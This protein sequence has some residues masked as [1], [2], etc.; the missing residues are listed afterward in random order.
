MK[1]SESWLR[2]WVNPNIAR[3]AL[4]D[5]LTMS[6]FEVEEMSSVAGDF[7]GVTVCEIVEIS[8][9]PNSEQLTVCEVNVG[10]SDRLIVVCGASNVKKGLKTAIAREGSRLPNNVTIKNTTIRDVVSQGMLCSASELGLSDENTGILELPTDA[11]IGKDLR[12]YLA[13]NDYTLTLA[14]MPNRGDCLS[15]KGMSRE[16]AALTDTRWTPLA[17]SET[18]AQAIKSRIDVVVDDKHACPNYVGRIIENIKPNLATPLWLKERLRRANV[19]SISPIVDITNYVMLELGQPMHAFDLSKLGKTIHIRQSKQGEKILLLD[20]S[21]KELNDNSLIIAD[22]NNP[23]A[24]AGVMGGEE[25]GVTEN[26]TAIFLESACFLPHVVAKQRQYYGLNSESAYRFERAVDPT[27]QREALERAT[28]LVLELTGGIPGPVIEANHT[29]NN[30]IAK[31]IILSKDKITNVLGINISSETIC[32]I[33]NRLGLTY[34]QTEQTFSVNIP[35]YRHDLL[36]E[37]DLIEEIAR[38]YGYDKIPMHTLQGDLAVHKQQ[39]ISVN[40]DWMIIR[41]SLCD[42]GYHEIV[43]YSFVDK[44]LQAMLNPSETARELLNPITADMTVMRTNLWP[45]LINTLL[46]NK[47]RQQHRLR[48]F[49][50]GTCFVT[51]DNKL[52]EQSQLGGILMGDDY[53]EQWGITSKKID[54]FDLKGDI[55]NL[56]SY[57]YA[58]NSIEFAQDMHPALHPG[59][60]AAIRIN[61]HH[62]GIMGMLHPMLYQTFDLNEKIALFALDLANLKQPYQGMYREIAKFPE[63]RRDLALLVEQS[64][65]SKAIQ[66]TIKELAGDWLKDVFIFDVYQGKGILP[67]LKSI[68]VA[69]I[70]QHPQRT[71]VDDE[72]A[73]LMEHVIKGIKEQLGAQLRS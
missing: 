46:Y 19:R 30:N 29:S 49:E 22:E 70:L 41:K 44:K 57:Y 45:G 56:L 23:L 60:T 27:L 54:F 17:I 4:S 2:E 39:P 5:L 73:A 43:S 42:M 13:L 33:F 10:D 40:Q 21:E 15:I 8:P 11:P 48:L 1:F 58:K 14:I 12:N 18:E 3:D 16:I 47:S 36:L 37:E 9:H 68:A 72:V 20:G 25:S 69:L 66:Y 71:L 31:C 64:I 6:G 52:T 59:Q 34:Q 65:P 32:A 53:P 35:P 7:S 24:I 67:G 62:C 38:L 55:E 26:T 63:I 50:I 61:G 28:Q 51:K